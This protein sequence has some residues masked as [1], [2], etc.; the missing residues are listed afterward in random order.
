MP[1]TARRPAPLPAGQA[2]R[3]PLP[4][5]A[6]GDATASSVSRTIGALEVQTEL[7]ELRPTDICRRLNFLLKLQTG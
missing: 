5:V 2:L 4:H 7:W 3:V 1:H 6:V